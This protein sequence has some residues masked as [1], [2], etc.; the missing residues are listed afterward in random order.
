MKKKIIHRSSET[1]ET[2]TEEFALANKSTT[3][4]ETVLMDGIYY[5]G[6]ERTHQKNKHGFTGEHH[7]DHPEWYADNQLIE[8]AQ[9][10]SD[11]ELLPQ[12]IWFPKNWDEEWFYRLCKKPF[13]KRLEIAGAMLAAEYDRLLVLEER[14]EP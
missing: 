3:Q 2:V 10:L 1:G 12:D 6:L 8:A 4:K 5:F 14:K 13:K 11:P 9:H 7:A